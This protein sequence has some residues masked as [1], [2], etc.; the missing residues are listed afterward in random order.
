MA[1]QAEQQENIHFAEKRSKFRGSAKVHLKHLQFE[2]N[3]IDDSGTTFLNSKNITRLVQIFRLEGC[4][5][6]DL[7]HRVPVIINVE[8][9][10]QSIDDSGVASGDLLKS[11]IPPTL[12]FPANTV[13]RCLHGRHRIAAAKAFLEVGNKWW[14]IDFYSDGL[15]NHQGILQVPNDRT[16]LSED[17]RRDLREEY[18]NSRNFCDGDIYRQIRYCQKQQNQLGEGRWF[19]RLSEGKRKDL[20]KLQRKEDLRSLS[21]ALDRLL[22]YI[23]FWP[24]LQIGTFHRILNLKCSEV[25]HR[26]IVRQLSSR[27]EEL[28]ELENYLNHI[29][30]CW[31]NIINQREELQACIDYQTV[32]LL[33]SLCPKASNVDNALVVDLM[34]SGKL[35]P[36]ISDFDL[37]SRILRNIQETQHNIPSLHTFLE[38][39]KWLE[40]CAKVLGQLLPKSKSS[41]RRS[42][43]NSYTGIQQRDGT[44][45]V[46]Q[47]DLSFVER[48]G[49]EFQAAESGYRQ[50]WLFSWRHF[51]ELSATVPRK[52]IGKPKPRARACNEQYWQQ[53]ACLARSLGFESEEIDQLNG[54]DPDSKMALEFL[55]QARPSDSYY[56]SDE[57]RTTHARKICQILKAVERQT[58]TISGYMSE[59]KADGAITIDHRCGRPHEHS[60]TYSKAWFFLNEIYNPQI[61]TSLSHFSV[62]RDIFRAFF[63]VDSHLGAAEQDTSIPPMAPEKSNSTRR[64]TLE[65]FSFTR[66]K[67]SSANGDLRRIRSPQR[68]P[69][70]SENGSQPDQGVRDRSHTRCQ[71]QSPNQR[72]QHPQTQQRHPSP[73]RESDDVLQT[74]TVDDTSAGALFDAELIARPRPL[75]RGG[76]P[77][78]F[79][80]PNLVELYEN[81]CLL[82]DLLLVWIDHDSHRARGEHIPAKPVSEPHQGTKVAPEAI[83]SRANDYYFNICPQSIDSGPS[84]LKCIQI[85]SVYSYIKGINWDGVIYAFKR[86]GQDMTL[87]SF[88]GQSTKARLLEL[89]SNAKKRP[90]T[91]DDQRGKK[92]RTGGRDTVQDPKDDILYEGEEQ[93]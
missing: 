71:S 62:N 46:E 53:L 9:L 47:R 43:L 82:G 50:L 75:N 56:I 77:N 68:S 38:D 22:P 7:E 76:K 33:Q 49:S 91:G 11:H 16:D 69:S 64:V 15:W 12:T 58:C 61:S 89:E 66:T 74:Q 3:I 72:Q 40:P 81:K 30:T 88:Q 39:T 90:R 20:R 17:V 26:K 51:P 31:D 27:I 65:D 59:P 63:G 79:E 36:L 13:L 85:K 78:L 70:R 5:R 92:N 80:F 86:K 87:R 55:N 8:L 93:L 54:R 83:L 34:H 60:H 45:R 18:A 32:Q 37:R 52:D 84:E 25:S 1:S 29:R 28:Q 19:A 21:S 41:I 10:Q 2:A 24:G 23:G 44:F 42:F 67:R 35:F 14:T 57:A 48:P 73:H 6:L 4:N